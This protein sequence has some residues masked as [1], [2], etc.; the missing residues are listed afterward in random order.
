M[1]KE[2]KKEMDPT[3]DKD[4]KLEQN[5]YYVKVGNSSQLLHAM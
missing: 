1:K 3:K 4:L 2:R 5:K